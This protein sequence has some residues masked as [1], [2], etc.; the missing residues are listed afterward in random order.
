[1]FFV[2]L[3][4]GGATCSLVAFFFFFLLPQLSLIPIPLNL[5][6]SPL[7]LSTGQRSEQF[8]KLPLYLPWPVLK[9]FKYIPLSLPFIISNRIVCKCTCSS[10]GASN[11]LKY[12]LMG[13][14]W[15]GNL[16]TSPIFATIMIFIFCVKQKN[17]MLHLSAQNNLSPP[18]Y[19][20]PFLSH[21]FSAKFLGCITWSWQVTRYKRIIFNNC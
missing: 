6:Y 8:S 15:I 4:G 12:C 19:P 7:L 3:D 18:P 21:P 2:Y 17:R 13:D 5:N 16:T 11:S 10:P 20:P 14:C 1:M 9:V